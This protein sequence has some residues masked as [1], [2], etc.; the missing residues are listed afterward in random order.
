[1][2]WTRLEL[3][4]LAW[5][6]NY[7]RSMTPRERTVKL[8]T[9]RTLWV[10]VTLLVI[11]FLAASVGAGAA[12]PGPVVLGSALILLGLG[13]LLISMILMFVVVVIFGD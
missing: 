7:P 2:K 12:S 4:L 11:G 8:M 13:L 10:S 1:M 9:L 6:S 3:A 5:I